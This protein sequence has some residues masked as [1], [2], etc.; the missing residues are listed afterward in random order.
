MT[1]AGFITEL[2]LMQLLQLSALME[3]K[4]VC[5]ILDIDYFAIAGTLLGSFRHGGFIP[6][7]T[8][9][10]VAMFRSDYKKFTQEANGVIDP[11][12]I[13]Q[14][15]YNDLNNRTCFARIR[16]RGTV[17]N[18]LENPIS[19]YFSGLYVD[20]F[21][22]DNAKA[23]PNTLLLVKHKFFKI[24]VRLKAFRAGKVN[25]STR[26]NSLIGRLLSLM[27]L[28]LSNKRLKNIIEGFVLR[29]ENHDC[30]LVTNYN[31]K[32]G[33]VKQTMPRNIYGVPRFNIFDGVKLR[34]PEKSESWLERI[35]GDYKRIPACPQ[36]TLDALLPGY[37]VDFGG[38]SDL[39]TKT[40]PEVRRFLN[41]PTL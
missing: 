29:F 17:F 38:Y 14:S 11:K 21:P 7:D 19:E 39:L 24:L 27:F 22:I 25:S 30:D 15:D 41:L 13:V 36:L 1:K 26:F 40:E 9:A 10:D 34:V 37:E 4:R 32:Y 33:L 5:S 8:D 28:F 35:Y 16:V 2:R 18:E 31:S 6:W 23:Q 12:F 20:I 3:V